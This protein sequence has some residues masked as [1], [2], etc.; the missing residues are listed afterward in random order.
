MMAQE[1][2][3]KGEL[4]FILNYFLFRILHIGF[5]KIADCNESS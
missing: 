3:L 4:I 1:T 2:E 5:I